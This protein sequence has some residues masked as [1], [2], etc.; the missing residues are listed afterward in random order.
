MNKSLNLN[1]IS[2]DL[3]IEKRFL[4]F[5]R[6][7]IEARSESSKMYR[8][9]VK[10]RLKKYLSEKINQLENI[11]VEDINRLKWFKKNNV[12]QSEILRKIKLN[13]LD[14]SESKIALQTIKDF[15]EILKSEINN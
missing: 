7:K 3:N 2:K 14:E 10:E 9:F 13:K 8:N 12:F 6:R 4:Y 1:Q 11:S 15:S 5:T